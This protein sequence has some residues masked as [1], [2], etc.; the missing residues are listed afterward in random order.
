MAWP[1]Y[2]IEIEN[3]PGWY[4]EIRDFS[5]NEVEEFEK[6][7]LSKRVGGIFDSLYPAIKGWYLEDIDGNSIPFE[8]ESLRDAPV[9]VL[10]YVISSLMGGI[11]SRPFLMKTNSLES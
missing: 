3:C 6:S 2:R 1:T 9:S 4:V 5:V 7:V 8:K 11:N 10:R